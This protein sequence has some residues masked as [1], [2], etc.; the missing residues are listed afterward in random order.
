MLW[1][2]IHWNY[3]KR[4]DDDYITLDREKKS[5][6]P[7]FQSSHRSP[8]IHRAVEAHKER[9]KPNKIPYHIQLLITISIAVIWH[10]IQGEKFIA[11][12]CFSFYS[13]TFDFVLAENLF[14]ILFTVFECFFSV[15]IFALCNLS[16]PE[17]YC[18]Q[19]RRATAHISCVIRRN[20]DN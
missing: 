17:V 12:F 14:S 9:E 7:L 18:A 2:G 20:A 6:I 16:L 11:A 10:V 19:I 1:I 15:H 8:T 4:Y 3:T 5:F 13:V